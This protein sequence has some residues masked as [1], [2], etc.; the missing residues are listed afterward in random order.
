M[1]SFTQIYFVLIKFTKKTNVL[2]NKGD[3]L[4]N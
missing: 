1:V 3:L 2:V 4:L